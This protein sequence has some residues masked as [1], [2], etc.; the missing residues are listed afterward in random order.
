M[1]KTLTKQEI[2]DWINFLYQDLL[3]DNIYI[4]GYFFNLKQ[5]P[6]FE[7]KKQNLDK[8]VQAILS[9]SKGL[10]VQFIQNDK[11]SCCGAL[12]LAQNECFDKLNNLHVTI[13]T[14]NKYNEKV[15]FPVMQEEFN[16]IVEELQ[17][18][19]QDIEHF[20]Q[21]L[22]EELNNEDISEEPAEFMYFINDYLQDIRDSHSS[23]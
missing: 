23:K 16:Y 17:A 4:G 15:E 14:K 12:Q 5:L 2:Q 13:Q 11:N 6:E 8:Q 20:K 21:F 7:K 3:Q 18:A 10:D 22:T 19:K 1:V 9:K